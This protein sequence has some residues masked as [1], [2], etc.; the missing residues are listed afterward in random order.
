MFRRCSAACKKLK[1]DI[2]CDL[3]LKQLPWECSDPLGLAKTKDDSISRLPDS[4]FSA[5]TE[6]ISTDFFTFYMCKLFPD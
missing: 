6:L 1:F 4:A 5:T 3:G 2:E